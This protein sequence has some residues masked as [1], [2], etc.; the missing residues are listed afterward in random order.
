MAKDGLLIDLSTRSSEKV[1]S[2]CGLTRIMDSL[3]PEERTA[4]ENALEKINTDIGVGRAKVY[5][6]AW[7]AE[8][9]RKNGFEISASTISRHLARRCRCD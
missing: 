5:S 7:L 1:K 2:Y 9:L 6:A 4:I 3:G 8:V